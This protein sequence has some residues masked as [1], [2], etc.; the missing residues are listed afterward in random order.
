[1]IDSACHSR[2]GSQLRLPVPIPGAG[3]SGPWRIHQTF[4]IPQPELEKEQ[5]PQLHFVAI[6]ALKKTR[7]PFRYA[8]AIYI[9]LSH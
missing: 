6:E 5:L 9:A 3:Q 8:M 1:M 2:L 7:Q 4:S